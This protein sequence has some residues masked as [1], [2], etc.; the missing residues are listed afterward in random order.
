MVFQ[1]NHQG[2]ISPC[3]T[4]EQPV[5]RARHLQQT[6]VSY[7][8]RKCMTE[9]V[10]THEVLANLDDLGEETIVKWSFD[11]FRGRFLGGVT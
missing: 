8:G 2:Y 3:A 7:P 5:H 11:R 10:C 6:P 1:V 4:V 9:Q